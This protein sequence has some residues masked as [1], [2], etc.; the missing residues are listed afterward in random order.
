MS[1]KWRLPVETSLH[2]MFST[3][4]QT[5]TWIPDSFFSS[6]ISG[7]IPSVKDETGA[8]F[9]DRDP[10]LFRIVLNFLRTRDVDL[11]NVNVSSLR[12]EA[13][14]YGV[15]P[16][17]KRLAVCE[18][19][20]KSSC[21]SILFYAQLNPPVFDELSLETQQAQVTALL[22]PELQ[23][24]VIQIVGH[25]NCIA[26]AYNHCVCVLSARES[27]G[28]ELIHT[29]PP[30]ER[31]PQ[32]IALN[33]RVTATSLGDKILAV[34]LGN[35]I[36]IWS[37]S[38][39]PRLLATFDM[40]I[41]IDGL[42]FINNQL[43]AISNTGKV[44]VW[45]S[46]QRHWQIQELSQIRS[47]DTAGSYLI[48]GCSNGS[49]YYIDM[50]KFPVRM[51]DNDLLVTELFQ[52]PFKEEVTALSI[53]MPPNCY[54][55]QTWMEVAYGTDRGGVRVIVRHPENI[56]HTP[57]L[58]QS[59][60]VHSNP[61]SKVVLGEKHLVS[62]CAENHIRS[63]TITRFRGRIST[64][65]G[66]TP[67]ASFKV[68]SLEG[69][70][71][72]YYPVNS[73]G[74]YGEGDDEQVFVQRVIP[75]SDTIFVRLSS[76]GERV[77]EINSVD[78]TNITTYCVHECE[79]INR[80]GM[81]SRRF[82]FTGHVNG[83]VQLWDLTTALEIY[84]KLPPDQEKKTL[85]QQELL[86]LLKN[87]DLAGAS[88][89]SSVMPS[90][91]P[92]PSPSLL[93]IMCP[94]YKPVPAPVSHM[95]TPISTPL[96]RHNQ[97]PEEQDLLLPLSVVDG[98]QNIRSSGVFSGSTLSLSSPGVAEEPRPFEEVHVPAVNNDNNNNEEVIGQRDGDDKDDKGT[99]EESLGF[100]RVLSDATA[101]YSSSSSSTT[102]SRPRSQDSTLDGSDGGARL[103]MNS[104]S[105]SS[106]DSDNTLV[107]SRP[108]SRLSPDG[109]AS[110]SS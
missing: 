93:S 109:I 46:V 21:G 67:I 1:L 13:E 78:G 84:H 44:A 57:Q 23:R 35:E 4:R 100:R 94:G 73:I 70:H 16:L 37:I 95:G 83:S 20:E 31:R 63:W 81:R 26:V 90:R 104:S 80:V 76:T 22:K 6:L 28:W 40:K 43:V 14:F 33:A 48:L 56:G 61:V 45:Q 50:E 88:R 74:P 59:Y 58:F 62:V 19:L 92:S 69:A 27:K 87:C 30:L 55:G 52:D 107:P 53:F 110:E 65:P 3:S 5:L 49:I 86:H 25:S 82:I 75:D 60:N 9:I 101:R 34:V 8:I 64:Q 85:S 39:Q 2:L 79:A 91:T 96:M 98:R 105:V 17:V 7:R 89:S 11:K 68:L 54:A 24:Q 72:L 32:C 103:V 38:P 66:S 41:P 106:I 42:F 102:S 71:S 47:Y 36:K 15:H 12:H 108:S 10:S 97:G 99:D 18:E 77:C 29:T 51:K